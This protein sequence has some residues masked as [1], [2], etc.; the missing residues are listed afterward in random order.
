MARPSRDRLNEL[1][2]EIVDAVSRSRAVILLKDREAVRLA[3]AQALSDELTRQEN[4]E[5]TARKRIS[6]MKRGPKANTPEWEA[7]FRKFVD[8]EYLR[9][10]L[11]S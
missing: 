4:R 1:A 8:E 3:V 9:E 7:L 2:R 5:E 10:G 11:D 6:A